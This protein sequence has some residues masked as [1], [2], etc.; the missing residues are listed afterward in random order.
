[1]QK[2][3]KHPIFA[4][5]IL[6]LGFCKAS[7]SRG[8]GVFVSRIFMCAGSFGD[9]SFCRLEIN[10]RYTQCFKFIFNFVRFDV[11]ICVTLFACHFWF[12][13]FS[14][15]HIAPRLALRSRWGGTQIQIMRIRTLHLLMF[16]R[17]LEIKLF[18]KDVGKAAAALFKISGCIAPLSQIHAV[19][20]PTNN[21]AADRLRETRCWTELKSGSERDCCG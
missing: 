21:A 11:S 4:T 13:A 17:L 7:F 2:L 10:V 14:H 12:D 5:L 15:S 8:G 16:H 18:P 9:I 6:R 20:A 19:E 3:D 1:M